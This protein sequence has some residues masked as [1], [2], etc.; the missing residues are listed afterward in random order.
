MFKR[1]RSNGSFDAFNKSVLEKM[2]AFNGNIGDLI[3]KRKTQAPTRYSVGKT[4]DEHPITPRDNYS[5]VESLL[6]DS[7]THEI[8]SLGGEINYVS[9]IHDEID[10]VSLPARLGL[11]RTMTGKKKA[12]N[13][14][15]TAVRN[16]GIDERLAI[17]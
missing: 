8:E 12:L 11:L 1:I 3:L 5:K 7:L 14:I 15:L 10:V 2:K 17:S 13:V 4:L 9:Q 16:F 6:L